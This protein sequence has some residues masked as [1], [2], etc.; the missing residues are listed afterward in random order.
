M[1]CFPPWDAWRRRQSGAG[2]VVMAV[3]RRSPSVAAPHPAGGALAAPATTAASAQPGCGA[4][5]TSRGPQTVLGTEPAQRVAVA[6]EHEAR[7]RSR[8]QPPWA[9][10]AASDRR[11]R[12]GLSQAPGAGWRVSEG[13]PL[14]GQ[15]G[16]RR[17][18]AA[19]V[20]ASLWAWVAWPPWLAGMA[21]AGPRT[22]GRPAAA[23]RSASPS[24]GHRHATATTR[25]GRDGAMTCRKVSGLVGLGRCPRTALCWS[26]RQTD[27]VRAC[28]SMPQDHGCCVV[29]NR[30]RSPPAWFT[31]FA[32]DQHTTVVCWGGGLNK[33]HGTGADGQ[34]ARVLAAAHRWRSASSVGSGP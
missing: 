31:G 3:G 32:H 18:R 4:R 13:P 29:D 28:R 12:G 34:N 25:P 5:A 23:P 19:L 26:R 8:P 33:Y 17:R 9:T 11:A 27:L 16:A 2:A 30:L 14:L 10:R 24:Q 20:W 6:R 15:G 21:R 7:G 1:R 22:P